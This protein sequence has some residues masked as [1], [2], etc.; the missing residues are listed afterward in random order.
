MGNSNSSTDDD[1]NSE[2]TGPMIHLY[3]GY[4][5]REAVGFHVF[6]ASVLEHARAPVALHPLGDCG[7]PVGSNAFTTS[8]FLVPWLMGYRG[9]AIYADASD[10]LLQADI[11]ELDG[12]FDVRKAVQVVQ[13]PKY[14]TKHKIKYRGTS[15]ECP[16]V[17]YERKNWASLMLINCA[18]PAW[19]DIGPQS[20]QA[21]PDKELLQLRHLSDDA[22][23]ALPDAW[24]RLVDEGHPVEGAKLMHYTA[25]IPAFE[26][27]RHTPGAE[28]WHRQRARMLE[29][30]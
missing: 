15:M 12:L 17:D 6:V 23:G 21:R 5:R 8:R 22:I 19:A 20:V 26:Y 24:N 13:H 14:A 2:H 28:P 3:C 25:G 11:V 4:D 10:M 27:Y 18:H 1:A 30:I 29:A 9:R 16:N 7:M